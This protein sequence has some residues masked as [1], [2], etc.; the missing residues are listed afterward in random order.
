MDLLFHWNTDFL[1]SIAIGCCILG[2]LFIMIPLVL[3]P[4]PYKE[5]VIYISSIIL[6]IVIFSLI[7]TAMDTI[8]QEREK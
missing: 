3:T 8:N 7:I 5:I 2:W 1:C 6:M 4:E